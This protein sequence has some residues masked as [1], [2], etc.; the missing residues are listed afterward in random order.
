MDWLPEQIHDFQECAHGGGELGLSGQDDAQS[1]FRRPAIGRLAFPPAIKG[2]CPSDNV[3]FGE[4]TGSSRAY[5]SAG[6]GPSEPEGRSGDAGEEKSK[7]SWCQVLPRMKRT[8]GR[9]SSMPL[10]DHGEPAI[11]YTTA[12]Q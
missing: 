6:R 9:P 3:F 8:V 2:L 7:I 1:F 11:V 5:R 12:I 4:V 10:R